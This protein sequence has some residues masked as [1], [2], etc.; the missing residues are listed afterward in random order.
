VKARLSAHI[1]DELTVELYKSFILDHIS[2]L[3]KIK[4]SLILCVQPGDKLEEFSK[5]LGVD[6][7]S[8]PQSGGS[9]GEKLKNAFRHTFSKNFKKAIVLASDS[10]DLPETVL[11]EAYR[12]LKSHDVV[13]GPTLDGGYYS[14][15]FKNSSFLPEIFEDIRWSTSVVFNQTIEKL[16]KLGYNIH[17]LPLW[18]DVDTMKDLKDLVKRGMNT[19]FRYSNTMNLILKQKKMFFD[20]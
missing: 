18:W 14:I 6:Y 17:V 16:N 9:L 19:D 1:D 8:I 3:K 4:K 5:W 2:K 20:E 13:I 11:R 10:P 7:Q 15:G 12:E